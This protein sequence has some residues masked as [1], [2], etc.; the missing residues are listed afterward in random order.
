MYYDKIFAVI[1]LFVCLVSITCKVKRLTR[2]N[3][4]V[5]TKYEPFHIHT[6]THTLYGLQLQKMLSYRSNTEQIWAF[7]YY[8]Y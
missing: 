8:L 7:E 4:F 5:S 6:A 3:D 2:C 1:P